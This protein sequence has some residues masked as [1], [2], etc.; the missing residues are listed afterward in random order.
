MSPLMKY[1]KIEARF[2]RQRSV[3][4]SVLMISFTVLIS[5]GV[6]CFEMNPARI[7]GARLR[8]ADEDTNKPPMALSI[9]LRES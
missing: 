3:P 8:K 7:A 9:I 1:R 6:N 4:I 5:I 2:A